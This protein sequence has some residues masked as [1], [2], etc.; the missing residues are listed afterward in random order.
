MQHSFS[1]IHHPITFLEEKLRSVFIDIE[2]IYTI[3]KTS[4]KIIVCK[5]GTNLS[6]SESEIAFSRKIRNT[7]LNHQWLRPQDFE[8]HSNHRN[9][10]QLSLMDE[11]E[12]RL[13]LLHFISPLDRLK[14]TLAICFPPD[15]NFFGIQKELKSL[16]TDEKSMIAEMLHKLLYFDYTSKVNEFKNLSR[17]KEFHSIQNEL[18]S[19]PSTKSYELFFISFCN[20]IITSFSLNESIEI[21]NEG[22]Q[23][24]S[25]K[26]KSVIEITYVIESA[27][28]LSRLI[29]PGLA[30]L[31]LTENHFKVIQNELNNLS[32]NKDKN[33]VMSS[34]DRV[35]E[36]LNKYEQA[37]QNLFQKSEV[38]NGRTISQNVSPPVSPPAIT[39]SIK[40]NSRK[41]EKYL[42]DYPEK[43]PLI[44]KSLKPIREMDILPFINN[45]SRHA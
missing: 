14:D 1:P 9:I 34:N 30:L 19:S 5:D 16:T 2:F 13:L 17:L 22:Y 40:K 8:L 11:L 37:A 20:S 26:T 3:Y 18:I 24:L 28:E 32:L 27:I 29:T 10:E 31:T 7:N 23:F 39:D 35:Y 25:E 38:I 43:W 42:K 6:S 41:I 21:T 4:E 15:V 45:T 12:N 33:T 36:L 44:R